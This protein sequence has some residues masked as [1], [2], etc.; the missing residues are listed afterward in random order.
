MAISRMNIPR[1]HY[2]L[3]SLVRKAV[4]AV[5]RPVK[6]IMKS[7]LGKA[8]LLGATM[9]GLGGG[10]FFG[11][12]LPNLARG[13][14][15]TTG[16]QMGNI[17]PNIGNYLMGQAGGRPG[18]KDTAGFLGSGGKLSLGKSAIAGSLALAAI[19]DP[20]GTAGFNMAKRKGTVEQYLRSYYKD[21]YKNNWEE[22]W[23]QSEEDDFV[24][25]YTSEYNQ[26]GR[27]GFYA[28]SPEDSSEL[29]AGAPSIKRVGNYETDASDRAQE[30]LMAKDDII[31]FGPEEKTFLFKNLAGMGGSDRSITMPQLYRILGSPNSP[32]NLA[33]AKALKAF[34][35]IKGFAQGGR[36]GLYAGGDPEDYLEEEEDDVT[37]WELQQE[38]GVPIGPM[39][40]MG[41]VMKLFET[42]YGFDR[43][44]FEDM[45][46]QY[47][48]SG[49]K[50]K[51]IKLYEF[52]IDFLG[53]VKRD[54]LDAPVQ[55]AA[56]GGR[57]GALGGGVMGGRVG[58]KVLQDYFDD[59]EEEYAQGGR[60]GFF[61]GMREQEQKQQKQAA[62]ESMRG[63]IG[64]PDPAPRP[65]QL[66]GPSTKAQ[67]A[68]ILATQP[69][70]AL[71]P[72]LGGPSTK[73][74]ATGILA[75][76][77]SQLGGAGTGQ[78]LTRQKI[79]D[80]IDMDNIKKIGMENAIRLNLS[81]KKNRYDTD[82]YDDEDTTGLAGLNFSNIIG[83]TPDTDYT[84]LAKVYGA[85]ELTE[86]GATPGTLWD[87]EK[88]NDMEK[89]QELALQQFKANK[90]INEIR[91][92]IDM[93]K[94][95]YGIDMENVPKDFYS[96]KED[97]E[98]QPILGDIEFKS[99]GG[100]IGALN[101]GMPNK[102]G[103]VDGPGGYAGE[104]APP[105]DNKIEGFDEQMLSEYLQGNYPEY[106]GERVSDR[107]NRPNFTDVE[108][109]VKIIEMGGS[110][111]DVRR[112]LGNEDITDEWIEK[113]IMWANEDRPPPMGI[114]MN[115][116]GRI[117]AF[118][119]GVMGIGTPGMR[120]PGI[121]QMA[122]DGLEYNMKAGGFQNLGAQ[123]GKDD[124]K[125]KLAKNEFVMTAD[126][127]RG[128]GDG[129]IEV[130]AQ[131]MYD[132]M[133]QLE[134]K[135]A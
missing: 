65:P 36:V 111:D 7:P 119:G 70:Q 40:G 108:A 26:G 129:N 11:R 112:V 64:R 124:V 51:G 121:P 13:A 60:I 115:Q 35:K 55:T 77:P 100:R 116:G 89:Y 10:T 73:A 15:G 102:R 97:F 94:S 21:Y 84:Q 38:E 113:F 12:G 9:Y 30:M 44:A 85:P 6:Q 58:L 27:V 74:Q 130:G 23:N 122:P 78:G 126:A 75:T 135:V 99:D 66:G 87:T 48:D 91:K 125:A 79:L 134:G 4:K 104:I 53:M 24:T 69:S 46:I 5:T 3:G 96:T 52:A 95:L 86:W 92:S 71:P 54:T 110:N 131:R 34:L 76:Q 47:G 90:P 105:L 107:Y 42:P 39:A 25:K 109:V 18:A 49:A 114:R 88:F 118:G 31:S 28:G 19:P 133:K 80:L 41:N 2:G 8:A 132:T 16:F 14:G 33:D 98:K 1:Q 62:R 57:V 67:A 68:K 50:E 45:L 17:M 59:D 123:E 128:A 63:P 72:Q 32:N 83:T 93:G 20:T 117:G 22:G 56:Q 101:G 37:P 103:L 29:D 127:V 120:L 61:T 82:I 43:D 106:K 81:K